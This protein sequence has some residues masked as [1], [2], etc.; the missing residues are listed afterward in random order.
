LLFRFH[1]YSWPYLSISSFPRR[2]W[3]LISVHYYTCSRWFLIPLLGWLKHLAI[4]PFYRLL[5]IG[6]GWA[7]LLY[8]V[9]L[10][11]KGFSRWRSL[12]LLIKILI[13][14]P[15]ESLYMW[16]NWTYRFNWFWTMHFWTRPLAQI[17]WLRWTFR[18]FENLMGP[19]QKIFNCLF[20]SFKFFDFL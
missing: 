3:I 4:S 6:F 8:S 19:H 13:H 9:R 7:R 18:L 10:L 5:S 15:M 1:H 14:S 16:I 2:F 17:P 12:I 20:I 11:S